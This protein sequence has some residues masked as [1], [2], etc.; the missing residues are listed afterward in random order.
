[1]NQQRLTT[2]SMRAWREFIAMESS[3]GVLLFIAAVLAMLMNN[4]PWH[5]GYDDLLTVSV[6]IHLG[7]FSL[8]KPL[9]LWI[10]DGLMAVFFLL[11]GLELK[12][13][14]VEGE[15]NTLQR[16]LL[17]A[18]GAVGGMLVPALF[19]IF[20][21]RGAPHALVGWAIPTA[22]D[23][24]FS[25]AILAVL[26]SRVPP[27]LKV[28]LTAL[29]IFDDM[30]A[31]LVIAFFYTKTLSWSL[32]AVALLLIL[33]LALMNYYRVVKTSAYL[34]VG[35]LLWLCVLKSGVHA[36]LAGLLLGLM[37]PLE[38]NGGFSMLRHLEHVL[39]PW[40]AYLVLPVFAF[41]NSGINCWQLGHQVLASSVTWGI[42]A[43]LFL[44]KQ[45]GIFGASMMAVRC[46]WAVLPQAV[47]ALWLYGVALIAGVGF[48]MSLFIGTLAFGDQLLYAE[49]VRLGVMLGSLLSGITGYLILR[50]RSG[51]L[52]DS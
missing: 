35:L 49:R 20:L 45:L 24:A 3:G 9:L 46:R 17:P 44:G 51:R 48:T 10:N 52:Q 2:Q 40:V 12:R 25:L 16:A 36:T 19:Y 7:S 28:F 27:A 31:V 47:D 37:I 26:G 30:G 32:L 14:L 4:S 38:E 33:L 13:E 21:N 41:A 34:F 5:R 39:H 1:M 22:T 11:V 6:G 18:I 43:G 8:V 50:W 42:V 29:A 23:I 15:L